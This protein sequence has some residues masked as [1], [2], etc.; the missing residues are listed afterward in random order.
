MK[1]PGAVGS[2]AR[3]EALSFCLHGEGPALV[4]LHGFTGSA[5]SWDP[6]LI[7]DLGKAPRTIIAVDLPGHGGS[8]LPSP[9]DRLGEVADAAVSVLDEVGVERAD[10]LGYSLGGRA[11]LHVVLRHPDR[12]NRLVLEG[13]SPG[14][15]D[16]AQRSARAEED[17]RLAKSIESD[18]LSAFVDRWM[19]QPI[20]ATQRT[21]P[22]DVRERERENRLAG[23][24]H[25]YAAALRS[26]GTGVQEPLWQALGAVV[27]PVLLVAGEHD[28]KFRRLAVDMAEALPCA[29]LE[30]VAGA[31]HAAH[32]ERPRA[33][34]A[35]VRR[36]LDERR[37]DGHA[38]A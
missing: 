26:M 29:R 38:A 21:L 30:I 32:L 34:A 27:A 6:V 10:W 9:G 15:A 4:L 28:E 31:G 11:A 35:T 2:A 22:V 14:I 33:F 23:S 8:P 36:F 24:A 25:G 12:V 3:P 17:A 5:S 1:R 16:R 13:A 18:G 19:A 20:F 37:Q 7:D